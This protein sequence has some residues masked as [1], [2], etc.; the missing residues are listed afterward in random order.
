MTRTLRPK[1]ELATPSVRKTSP[2]SYGSTSRLRE[3]GHIIDLEA[4]LSDSLTQLKILQNKYNLLAS[5]HEELER[6]YQR[7]LQSQET[8]RVGSYSD[9]RDLLVALAED[10]RDMHVKMDLMISDK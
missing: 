2:S 3:R 8:E 7:V 6:K 10:V 9:V 4:Q 1:A 5:K